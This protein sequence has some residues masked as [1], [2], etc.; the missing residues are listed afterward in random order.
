MNWANGIAA[1]AAAFAVLAG[2][3]AR[4]DPPLPPL[5]VVVYNSL[6]PASAAL[7]EFYARKRGI[8]AA[9]VFGLPLP[10]EEEISR[11]T[12]AEKFAAPFR[13][14][15]ARRGLWK[16]RGREAI[17]SRIRYAVLM[18]GVPL[19]IR[20]AAPPLPPEQKRDPLRD[21]DEASVDSEL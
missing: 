7:A 3:S 14:Q 15:M 20:S 21:R 6:D 5:T 12:F 10:S 9:N 1:L 2:A 4:A 17:D 19:K 16:L 8:P 11:E 13:E 18:R